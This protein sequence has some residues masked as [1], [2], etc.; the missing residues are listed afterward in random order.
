M[1][2]LY[3][4]CAESGLGDIF[5]ELLYYIVV[6]VSGEQGLADIS[7]RIGDVGLGDAASARERLENRIKF[8]S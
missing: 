8:V 3:Y 4:L 7:H 1:E 2:A 6:N 5:T